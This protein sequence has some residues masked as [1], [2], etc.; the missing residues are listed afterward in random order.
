[1][2][3]I[4][5][6]HWVEGYSDLVSNILKRID[7]C[8]AEQLELDGRYNGIVSTMRQRAVK[9]GSEL[10]FKGTRREIVMDLATEEIHVREIQ[11]ASNEKEQTGME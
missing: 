1:M 9:C 8:K 7:I 5:N 11:E 6:E 4:Y 3:D 2:S 10:V